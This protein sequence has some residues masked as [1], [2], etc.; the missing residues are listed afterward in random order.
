MGDQRRL[1][2]DDRSTVYAGFGDFRGEHEIEHVLMLS[3]HAIGSALSCL[4][5]LEFFTERDFTRSFT[6]GIF[7]IQRP[8]SLTFIGPVV[9][10]RV[11]TRIPVEAMTAGGA[12]L[13]TARFFDQLLREWE[14]H[15]ESQCAGAGAGAG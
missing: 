10:T 8:A 11:R 4:A 12:Q 13:V 2:G 3:A 5:E 1:E 7:R 14:L 15:R 9:L 6:G